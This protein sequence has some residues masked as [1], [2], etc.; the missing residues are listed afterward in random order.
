MPEDEALTINM[1]SSDSSHLKITIADNEAIDSPQY[2]ER[3]D[4]VVD[5]NNEYGLGLIIGLN[6][7]KNHGGTI[8][9]YRNKSKGL[10]F[11]VILP[12]NPC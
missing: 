5:A 9:V 4:N 10:I 6:I 2:I 8:Q 11:E 1:A 7:V 3:I 12:F